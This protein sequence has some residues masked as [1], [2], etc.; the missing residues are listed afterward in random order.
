MIQE[1]DKLN[2]PKKYQEMSA[3]DL[4]K[5]KEKV[6]AGLL[7]RERVVKHKKINGAKVSFNI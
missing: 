2:I 3:T 1:N 7:N 5:E 6:L 4:K